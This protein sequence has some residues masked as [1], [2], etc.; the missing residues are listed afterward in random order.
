[1]AGTAK[2]TFNEKT[3]K[4]LE[5]HADQFKGIQA[6]FKFEIAGEGGGVWTLDLKSTPYSVTEG[7]GAT[8]DCT[9]KIA[10]EDFQKL[11]DNFAMA[12][13]FFAAGKLKVDNPMVAMKL[14]RVLPLLNK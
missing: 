4:A 7:A 8:P 5:Q 9:I 3:P 2:E 12:M 13:Q 1:M 11:M 10:H 14:Q 6:V